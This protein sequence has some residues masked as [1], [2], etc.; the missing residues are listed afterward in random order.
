M[1]EEAKQLFRRRLLDSAWPTSTGNWP[2][3]DYLMGDASRVAD[4]YLYTV[5]RWTKPM[6]LDIS[7]LEMLNAFMARM[8]AR[9]AVQRALKAEGLAG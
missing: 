1:P 6:K 3:S 4:G 2:A 9:P 7:G 8:R 5:T